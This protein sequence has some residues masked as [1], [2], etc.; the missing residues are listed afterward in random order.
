M[1]GSSHLKRSLILA[2]NIE[3][4]GRKASWSTERRALFSRLPLLLAIAAYLFL[5]GF[6]ILA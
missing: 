2:L 3:F 1:N 5:M 4:A 6:V